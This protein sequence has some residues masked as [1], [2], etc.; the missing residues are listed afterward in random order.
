MKYVTEKEDNIYFKY[1]A[2][3]KITCTHCGH[4]IYEMIYDREIC[5]VCKRWIYKN[6]QIEFRYKLKEAMKK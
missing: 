4:T 2:E 1:R 3:H 5:S 6:K